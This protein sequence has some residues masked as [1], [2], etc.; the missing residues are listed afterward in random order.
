[1]EFFDRVAEHPGRVKLTPVSGQA[2]TYDMERAD[3]PLIPGTPVNRALFESFNNDIAALQQRVDNALFEMRQRVAVGSLNTG[4][5]IGLYENGVKVPF[6]VV[7]K[8]FNSTG[9]VL[10]LRKDIYK[11]DTLYNEGEVYYSGC[12]A[13]LWLNNEYINLLDD[14]TRGVIQYVTIASQAGGSNNTI[15]RKVLFLSTREYGFSPTLSKDEGE[16]NYYFYNQ[17]DA[18]RVALYNGVPSPHWTRTVEYGSYDTGVVTAEG[19]EVIGNPFTNVCGY[20]PAFTL[21]VDFEVTAGVPNTANT[22]AT[23]EVI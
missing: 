6:I 5:I 18:R 4:S 21:P 2:N 15:S 1:M 23:A 13:D 17:T 9:R 22:M 14:A 19:V 8:N 12:K 11:M 16:L 20:R 3:N 7:H 10:V